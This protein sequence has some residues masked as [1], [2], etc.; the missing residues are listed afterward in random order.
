MAALIIGEHIQYLVNEK[1]FHFNGDKTIQHL[2]TR[3]DI[4]ELNKCIAL[5]E[6]QLP[7]HSNTGPI[8]DDRFETRTYLNPFGSGDAA[9]LLAI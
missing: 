1:F 8:I 7:D 3:K 6:S 9:N 2:F 5:Y 4:K